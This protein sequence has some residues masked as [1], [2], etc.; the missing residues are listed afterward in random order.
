MPENRSYLPRASP[1]LLR[2]FSRYLRGYFRKHF[3][4]IRISRGGGELQDQA[5]PLV[6]YANHASW[7][8]PILF[9]LLSTE[10]F[11]G[12]RAYG[13]M[14]AEALNK[15]PIFKRLGI[16]GIERGSHTGAVTFLRTAEAIL[17]QDRSVLWLTA[18]GAFTDSRSRPVEL[19]FGL[20][21]LLRR[22]P[23]LR[24]L[25]LAIEYPFW[26]ERLPEVL[27][28]FGPPVDLP[29]G[30][31]GE[32]SSLNHLLEENLEQTMDALADESM[33][34]DPEL[35]DTLILGKAGVGGIYDQWRR[36]RARRAGEELM[37]SHE[38][39]RR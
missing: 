29:S 10:L 14:D 19:Q 6:V 25:P 1:R 37:L 36:W 26:N 24:V 9:M 3:D 23:N 28:R 22:I 38:D 31:R 27:V 39:R 5:G 17:S 4:A 7:W 13:P 34:R 16:F 8:D 12:R 35:F 11:P 2:W 20:A 18:E 15:Y 21:H 32:V 33:C 30:G